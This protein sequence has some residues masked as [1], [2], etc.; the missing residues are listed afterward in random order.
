MYHRFGE[1]KYPTTNTTI[2]Q[3]DQHI[4]LYRNRQVMPLE[5]AI[6]ALQQNKPLPEDAIAITVDDAFV[7]FYRNGY[8]KFAEAKLPVTLFVATELIGA[9][10]YMDTQM[11]KEVTASGLVT[12]ESHGG[13]HISF[14]E[15]TDSQITTEIAASSKALASITG[16]PPKLLSYPY[17]EADER[18]IGLATTSGVRAAFGQH[19]GAIG[20]YSDMFY[21]PRFALNEKYGSPE[22]FRLRLNT[23]PLPLKVLKATATEITLMAGAMVGGVSCFNGVTGNK[24]EASHLKNLLVL[25]GNFPKGRNRINCT[26]KLGDGKWGWFGYQFVTGK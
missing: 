25:K 10:D 21:L 17:G 18:V 12:L 11:L 19:S 6:T 13:D 22:R 1:A 24:L 3:L 4:A 20:E 26:K 2:T 7:S 15:K 8:P 16:T 9:G 14:L 23:R 5:E